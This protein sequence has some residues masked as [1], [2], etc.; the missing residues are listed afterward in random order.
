MTPEE[1]VKKATDDLVQFLKFD[2]ENELRTIRG[3]II[4]GRNVEANGLLE[5]LQEKLHKK[6]PFR[7]GSEMKTEDS[8]I[9]V[10]LGI[11]K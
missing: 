9:K 8:D 3:L 5:K 11:E 6:Y 10:L 2:L 1:I 4:A 7:Y